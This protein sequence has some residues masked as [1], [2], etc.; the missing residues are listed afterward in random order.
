MQ[1]EA[2]AIKLT[3]KV[4]GQPR[5]EHDVLDYVRSLRPKHPKPRKLKQVAVNGQHYYKAHSKQY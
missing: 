2:Q 5:V 4:R 1:H 3:V